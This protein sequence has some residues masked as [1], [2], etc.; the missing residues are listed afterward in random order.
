MSSPD[1]GAAELGWSGVIL[2]EDTDIVQSLEELFRQA[3]DCLP[4]YFLKPFAFHR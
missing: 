4:Y 3:I 2:N 1:P